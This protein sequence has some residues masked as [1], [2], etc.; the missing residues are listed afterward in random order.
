MTLKKLYRTSPLA[1][2]VALFLFL[3]LTGCGG[4]A[5]EMT[6]TETVTILGQEDVA[7][8]ERGTLEEAVFV[9]G[10]LEPYLRVE[11][12]AQVPG[13]LG[14]VRVE[15]GERVREGQELTVIQ[16]EGIR[17]QAAS[18]QAAV[19]SARSNLALAERQLESARTLYEAG[20]MSEIEFEQAKTA[21]E[22]A[23]AQLAAAQAGAA[24]TAEQAQRAVVNAPITGVVSEKMVEAG[25]AVN[26]GQPLFTIVNTSQLELKGQVPVGQAARLEVGQTVVF[27]L[28]AYPG[29]TFRGTVAR[30]DPTADTETRQLGVYL[31]LQNPGHLVGGLFATGR[32][33]ARE[34]E[35]A[36]LVPEQ[37]V[38]GGAENT[39]VFAVEDGRIARQY[40]TVIGRDEAR[41]MVA[42]EGGG[43]EAGDLVLT[44]QALSVRE[45]MP[46]E[47][48]TTNQVPGAVTSDSV[49][50]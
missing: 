24:G 49:E 22:A 9:T 47:V 43:V 18:A 40:V 17:S 48:R 5:D 26:P 36:L 19:A 7:E 23:Q 16:A 33:I 34:V 50:G 38:R 4:D 29:Q 44:S 28:D 10:S 45:G 6:A 21:Y 8:V 12:K 31:R 27:T 15:E 32:V 37:A 39:Y 13:T 46:V 1:L 42:V 41:G 3:S 25:E 30:L 14:R 11:V 35:D 20:A 2:L